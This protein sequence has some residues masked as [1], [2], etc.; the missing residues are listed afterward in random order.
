M[1]S[2]IIDKG[3]YGKQFHI[4]PACRSSYMNGEKVCEEVIPEFYS[5]KHAI[6]SG[7]HKTN[8][9]WF[10]EPGKSYVW[11]CPDCWAKE[12]EEWVNS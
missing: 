11:V 7:W 4:C 1:A 2:M 5:E 8:D 9:L 6:D 10:C 3:K 12:Y